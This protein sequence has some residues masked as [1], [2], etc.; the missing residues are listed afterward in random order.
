MN[1]S[2]SFL[3]VCL[4][5]AKE[6]RLLYY[7]PIVGR[8][9]NRWIH[10]LMCMLIAIFQIQYGFLKIQNGF[11]KTSIWSCMSH[12]F[13]TLC[14]SIWVKMT[15]SGIREPLGMSND[16]RSHLQIVYLEAQVLWEL[17]KKYKKINNNMKKRK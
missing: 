1:L 9:G 15:Y 14:Q 3:T 13:S 5:K 8:K 12:H 11:L 6:P 2:I 7:L 17:N 4:F 16:D 10:T